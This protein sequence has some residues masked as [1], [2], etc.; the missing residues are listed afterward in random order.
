MT[1]IIS[2]FADIS[3]RYEAAFVDLWGCVHDGVRALPEAV[4]AL[5]AY[6]QKGGIVV[7]VTNS[8]RARAG[9]EKQLV[10][11]GVPDD[12]WDSIATS[13][14]SARA[15]MFRLK[16]APRA[17]SRMRC[18]SRAATERRWINLSKPSSS[19]GLRWSS[20]ALL[21]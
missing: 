12:A 17:S 13:G 2:S 10:S 15:A 8:P 21:K 14:D 5:Q 7:L 19:S 20:S 9:V 6:R 1:Q 3:D 16:P 4:A 18:S 11:F